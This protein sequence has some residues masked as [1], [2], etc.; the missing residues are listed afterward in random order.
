MAK[1]SPLAVRW[2]LLVPILEELIQ[3]Q[4][5]KALSL[6]VAK[7]IRWECKEESPIASVCC[8]CSLPKKSG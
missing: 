6:S 4:S 7:C 8:C 5:H 1:T 2:G 3:N